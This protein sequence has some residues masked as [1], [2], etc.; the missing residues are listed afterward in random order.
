MCKTFVYIVIVFIKADLNRASFFKGSQ[1]ENSVSIIFF[2]RVSFFCWAQEMIFWRM[3]VTKE[4]S[5][6][7]TSIVWKNKYYIQWFLSDE[8]SNGSKYYFW[9]EH[10]NTSYWSYRLSHFAS[11]LLP[12][13]FKISYVCL[14]EERKSY[15]FG[16]TWGWANTEYKIQFNVW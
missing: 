15:R 11:Y 13:F 12:I 16:T 1:N 5:V 6:E 9:W 7:L 2:Q 10:S 14:N 4:L 8:E 3:L